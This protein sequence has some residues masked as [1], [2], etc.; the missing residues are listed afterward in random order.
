M[1]H[2]CGGGAGAKLQHRVAD[3]SRQPAETTVRRPSTSSMMLDSCGSAEYFDHTRIWLC[4]A[5]EVILHP[6]RNSIAVKEVAKILHSSLDI[7]GVVF[8]L[9]PLKVG[10]KPSDTI[11]YN[12][13]L[14]IRKIGDGPAQLPRILSAIEQGDPQA[15]EQRLHMVNS[16]LHDFRSARMMVFVESVPPAHCGFRPVSP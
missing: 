8:S 6:L 16:L 5:G 3:S 15:A 12:G 1:V 7:E 2:R 11:G 14:V 10:I 13:R 4:F 9:A